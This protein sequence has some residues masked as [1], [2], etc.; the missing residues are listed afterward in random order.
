MPRLL[1]TWFLGS[2]M[3]AACILLAP[4]LLQAQERSYY[5]ASGAKWAKRAPEAVGMDSE[6]L[7]QAVAFAQANETDFPRDLS[8]QEKIFG[9]RL[10][11]LPAERAGTNGLILRHG[12]IVAQWGD[13]RHADPTY[14]AAKSFLSTLLG[15]ALYRK[16]IADI[17]EPVGKTIHDGGYDLPHN[18][19]ITWQH[20]AQQNSEWEGEMW[21]KNSNFI[22]EREFGEGRHTVRGLRE[23]GTFFEYNDVRI[24]RL[25]LS[26]LRVVGVQFKK[27][28]VV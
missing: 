13:T 25:A 14:S 5:P 9:R 22:G 17:K 2:L 18:T 26:L 10:G 7:A 23:P 21:G 19:N 12:Y 15:L 4:V 28:K 1:S 20:H 8:T 16:L 6:K 24:N 27:M 11:P 3:A